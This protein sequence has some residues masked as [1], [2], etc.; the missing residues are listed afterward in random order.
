MFWAAAPA[1]GY[2]TSLVVE[3]G[4]AVDAGASYDSTAVDP[5]RFSFY[6]TARPSATLQQVEQAMDDSHHRDHR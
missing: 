5:T 2:I 3:Q 4:I 1:A 6:V